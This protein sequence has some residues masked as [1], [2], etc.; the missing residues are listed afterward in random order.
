LSQPSSPAQRR[1]VSPA[2]IAV[3]V[4]VVIATVLIS[5]AG[6]YTDFLWFN[7]LGFQSVFLTQIIAQVALFIAGFALMF[8]ITLL[9][10]NLATDLGLSI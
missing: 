10:F 8:A 1:G 9:S 5:A 7:H 2:T 6:I 4:L 3:G